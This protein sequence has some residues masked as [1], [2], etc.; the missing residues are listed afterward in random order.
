MNVECIS[1]KEEKDEEVCAFEKDV[2]QICERDEVLVAKNAKNTPGGFRGQK[3]SH[4]PRA[5]QKS[6]KCHSDRKDLRTIQLFKSFGIES[7]SS[8][9]Q[10]IALPPATEGLDPSKFVAR[11]ISGAISRLLF[12]NLFS[13]RQAWPVTL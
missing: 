5:G 1:N 11:K 8:T 2:N 4:E 6:G 13:C 7:D 9:F 10:C 3:I 12:P